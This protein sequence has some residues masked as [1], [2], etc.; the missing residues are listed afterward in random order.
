MDCWIVIEAFSSE[1]V[2]GLRS[3]QVY[4]DCVDLSAV[5]NASKLC[6]RKRVK[7]K[8]P[9]LG[10]DPIRTELRV[11]KLQ[12]FGRRSYCFAAITGV[13]HSLGGLLAWHPRSGGM[14]DLTPKR[15]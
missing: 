4:A 3:N 7:T 8:N 5:E 9:E 2:T 15:R 11:R 1:V 12:N 6:G 13:F 14:T 10:S